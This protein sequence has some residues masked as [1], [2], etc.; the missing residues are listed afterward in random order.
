M[1]YRDSIFSGLLEP[2]S[3]RRFDALVSRHNADAYDKAFK[4]WDHFVLL[5]FAQLSGIGGLR[6]LE[7]AWNANANHH[8]HLGVGAIARSTV[9][10]ANARRPLA[11][12]TETFAM[13]SGLADRTSRREGQEMLRLID[14]TPIPEGVSNSV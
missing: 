11:V 10:D 7:V 2:I 8:Y 6:G 12:F 14:S 5:V 3:R 4:S 9:S 13:L 1:R